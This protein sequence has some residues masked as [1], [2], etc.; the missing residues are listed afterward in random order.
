VDLGASLATN[1]QSPELVYPLVPR[2]VD[3]SFGIS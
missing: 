3:L 1:E 2:D